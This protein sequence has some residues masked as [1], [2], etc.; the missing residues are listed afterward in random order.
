MTP[1]YRL[2]KAREREHVVVALE[3]AQQHW[4]SALELIEAAATVDEARVALCDAFGIT[5]QQAI[6]VTETQFRRVS[7]AD[8]S[9]ISEELSQLRAEIAGLEAE[10]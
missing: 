6:A 9:R 1:E 3:M 5:S 7:Q 2:R 4:R 8:R 10:L